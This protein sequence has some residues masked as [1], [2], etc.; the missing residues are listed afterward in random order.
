MC[1]A[2]YLQVSVDDVNTVKVVNCLE[3]LSAKTASILLCVAPLGNDAVK[4]LT[5]GYTAKTRYMY[6][7]D[8]TSLHYIHVCINL[9][10]YL[11]A[12]SSNF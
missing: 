1:I 4:Q 7:Y 12:L 2:I 6:T 11:G 10:P 3:N 5:T 8:T 9:C